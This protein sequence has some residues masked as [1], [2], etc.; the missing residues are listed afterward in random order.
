V[1]KGIDKL[2]IEQEDWDAHVTR[3]FAKLRNWVISR[4]D[5]DELERVDAAPVRRRA[6]DNGDTS[7]K[8]HNDRRP[9][10]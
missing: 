2:I 8:D 6:E 5:P 10:V 7:E 4:L 3:Q 1:G 9:W